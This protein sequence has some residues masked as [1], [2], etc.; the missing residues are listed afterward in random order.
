MIKFFRK[1]RQKMLSENKFSKYLIYAIGEIILVMIGI[2]LALQVNNWNVQR[3]DIA[4]E[5]KLLLQLKSDFN[6]NLAQ[7]DEKISMRS[8]ILQAS[9][10]LLDYIDDPEFVEFD[11]ITQQL[12]FLIAD[13]TFDPIKDNLIESGNIHLI[14]HDSL[15][16]KLTNWSADVYQLQEVELEYQKVRTEII[17]PFC[18]KTGLYRN[19]INAFWKDIPIFALSKTAPIKREIGNT[20]KELNVSAILNNIELEGIVAD[21]FSWSNIGNIQSLA[22]KHRIIE[23]LRLIDSEIKE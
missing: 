23:L 17:I 19:I 18:E 4:K 14:R 3:I 20:K 7:L 9:I 6:K 1:I 15:R 12:S 8:D 16:Q 5:Q 22:L 2:L 21:S 11:S 13:P 10:K